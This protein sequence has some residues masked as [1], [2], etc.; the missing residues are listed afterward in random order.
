MIDLSRIQAG[1][2][3]QGV[4]TGVRD[5]GAFININAGKDGLLHAREADARGAHVADMRERLAVGERVSVFVKHVDAA[6]SQFTLTL[7]DPAAASAAATAAMAAAAE[8]ERVMRAEA[9]REYAAR[10]AE[11]ARRDAERR[12]REEARE[13]R[14]QQEREVAEIE[15]SMVAAAEARDVLAAEARAAAGMVLP[16]AELLRGKELPP[17]PAEE[18][19]SWEVLVRVGDRV[20]YKMPWK[21]EGRAA[22]ETTALWHC[23]VW[24]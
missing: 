13:R 23:G 1:R 6:A 17:A 24:A 18:P 3:I 22:A 4:V 7:R 12:E 11:Q 16:V 2:A 14:R 15:A 20:L 19:T 9:E 10:E 5:F 21:R 8:R